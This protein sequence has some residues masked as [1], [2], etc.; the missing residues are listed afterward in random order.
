MDTYIEAPKGGLA[1]DPS[2][3]SMAVRIPDSDL[4][5]GG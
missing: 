1:E 3:I 4:C 2:T 5:F